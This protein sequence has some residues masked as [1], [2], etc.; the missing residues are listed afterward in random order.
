MRKRIRHL[1]KNKSEALLK[2]EMTLL[3]IDCENKN[4]KGL[5]SLVDRPER[6]TVIEK[7][8]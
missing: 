8:K 5:N 1:K 2:R 3:A 4:N 6:T 7:L